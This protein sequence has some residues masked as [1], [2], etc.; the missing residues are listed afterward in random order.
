[1]D[2]QALC[3]ITPNLK[4]PPD[5]ENLQIRIIPAFGYEELP[6]EVR[7]AIRKCRNSG[8]LALKTF[9]NS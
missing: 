7:R 8:V 9:P 6:S 2:R 4:A 1:L 5:N 3:Q